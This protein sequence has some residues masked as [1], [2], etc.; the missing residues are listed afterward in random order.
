MLS[1]SKNHHM[2]GQQLSWATPSTTICITGTALLHQEHHH[3]Y[4]H[5]KQNLHHSSACHTLASELASAGWAPCQFRSH[6]HVNLDGPKVPWR[7]RAPREPTP[8]D[9]NF[10]TTTAQHTA[11]SWT[12][13]PRD[14]HSARLHRAEWPSHRGHTR[15]L[16]KS[17]WGLPPHQGR[18]SIRYRTYNRSRI[19]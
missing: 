17:L 7:G 6:H 3:G 4:C 5:T 14:D 13:H 18:V 10:F 8:P 15:I 16:P 19:L 12:D 2:S 1:Y 11:P 9:R